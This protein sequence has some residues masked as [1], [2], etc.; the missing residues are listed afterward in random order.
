MS[1]PRGTGD[2]DA[3]PVRVRAA[4]AADHESAGALRWA[5]IVEEDG[6]SSAMSRAVFIAEFA[7]W[8]QAHSA[9]HRCFVAEADA[10]VV[11]MAW[12]AVTDRVPSPRALQRRT[13]DLQSVYVLPAFRGRGVG[14]RLIEAAVDAASREGAERLVVHS[15]PGAVS[16]YA[17]AG[18]QA[19]ELL[20]SRALHPV[21]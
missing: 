16:A 5:W 9:T 12:L 4:G 17:R 7:A 2:V 3:A 15:S 21:E 1:A 18:L 14:T 11:G 20:R 6:R 8:A 19:S 13:A 10:E